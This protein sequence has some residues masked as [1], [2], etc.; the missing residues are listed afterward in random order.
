MGLCPVRMCPPTTV[1]WDVCHHPFLTIFPPDADDEDDEACWRRGSNDC[2][3]VV[4]SMTKSHPKRP[5]SR[6]P[7]ILDSRKSRTWHLSGW[8]FSHFHLKNSG[9]DGLATAEDQVDEPK[10]WKSEGGFSHFLPGILRWIFDVFLFDLF[11]A[12]KLELDTNQNLPFHI[13]DLGAAKY[14][15]LQ[16]LS[17]SESFSRWGNIMKHLVLRHTHHHPKKNAPFGA[18][19]SVPRCDIS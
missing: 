11:P 3:K 13:S 14:M 19:L 8:I 17:N 5:R 12:S 7:W 1:V 2:R 9:V 4:L 15:N 10:H 16:F 18:L 6:I